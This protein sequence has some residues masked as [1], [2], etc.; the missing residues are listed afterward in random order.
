MPPSIPRTPGIYQWRCIPTGKIYIGSTLNLRRRW[1]E[2]LKALRCKQHG[3]PHLQHAWDKY[4]ENAFEFSILELV[5]FAEYLIEREQAWLDATRC[6]DPSMGFNICPTAGSSLG[7]TFPPET[8]D[9]LR[10]ARSQS[11]DGYVDPEGNEVTIKNLWDFCK[12]MG[13]KHSAMWRLA[14]GVGR[15]KSHKGWTHRDNPYQG[16]AQVWNGFVDPTGSPVGPIYNLAEFCRQYGLRQPHMQQVYIGKRP[17]HRGWT[18]NRG[19]D[20]L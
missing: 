5:M 15:T 20:G 7:R 12:R 13:L 6:Y 11:V 18:C 16:R 3:N 4:G 10:D 17:H 1:N 19:D 14:H 2:H 9:G 8:W